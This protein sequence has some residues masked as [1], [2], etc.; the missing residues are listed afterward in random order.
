M[1]KVR[2][3]GLEG[4]CKPPGDWFEA[5]ELAEGVE[6]LS[7]WFVGQAYSRHRHD[8]YAIGIS[9]VGVLRFDY[10]G[11]GQ[12]SLPGNAI[13][14]HPD[15]AHDGRSGSDIGFGYRMLYVEPRLVFDA[16]ASVTG[17]AGG[18][19]FAREPV[20]PNPILAATVAAAFNSEPGS[21]AATDVVVGLT[22]G[23]LHADHE[24]GRL[25]VTERID[26]CAVERT[27]EF[28]GASLDRQVAAEELELVSGLSRY[29]LARQFRRRCGTSPY[30]YSVMRRLDKSRQLIAER[31]GLALTAA[32]CG[33]A[34]Q[35]H[36][37][38][39][40]KAA[41]GI[42][43]GQYRDTGCFAAAHDA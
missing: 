17:K 14:L 35:A 29:E 32:E 30:R 7:A 4:S 27:R 42:T 22:R 41:Y 10:R 26:T 43:P 19:P 16:V 39:S 20:A 21:L 5:S 31:E 40:F 37:T 24:A 25:V 6:L 38:R 33:F 8:S 11:T 13:I 9:N 3:H 28:L 1:T 12:A 34:D 36:F 15:E 2:G 23:L 18:L